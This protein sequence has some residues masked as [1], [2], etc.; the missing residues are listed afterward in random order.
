MRACWGLHMDCLWHSLAVLLNLLRLLCLLC[1]L[2]QLKQLI[3]E[4]IH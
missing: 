1:L 3:H 2:L 4:S